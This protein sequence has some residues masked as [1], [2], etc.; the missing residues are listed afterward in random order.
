MSDDERDVDF[1]DES[2]DE[3]I[4]KPNL[5]KNKKI[6]AEINDD[7]E[8]YDSDENENENE[9]EN[10]KKE[11]D[12]DLDEDEKEEDMD[13]EDEY[14]SMDENEDFKS[15]LEKKNTLLDTD[16]S[17]DDEE[18]DEDED[19]EETEHYLKKFN[20]DIK[21]NVIQDF[22]PEL[23][24]HNS[25]EV[26]AMSVVT[27]NHIGIIIDPLHKTLPFLTKY[28]KA[29]ILGERAKQ[30]DAGATPFVSVDE[31]VVSGYLIALKELEEKRIPFIIKRPLPNGGCEYW[32]LSDL[33]IL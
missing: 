4:Y 33:E 12:E 20:E 31:N 24:Q 25:E 9:I 11:L 2:G 27:R 28:E 16:V 6:L 13:E 10:D 30:I 29:R 18:E 8:D 21:K 1:S 3:E 23:V 26:E 5:K 15:K 19:N 32:R 17:S 7:E 22:Y 14:D